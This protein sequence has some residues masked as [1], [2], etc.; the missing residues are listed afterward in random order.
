[1]V[2]SLYSGVAGMV[3]H[4]SKMDVIG[5][6]I[7]NVSTYGYKSSRATFRDVY[8][9]TSS[10]ASAATATSGGTNPTQIGYGAKLGSVDVNH[11]QSTKP[12]QFCLDIILCR[13]RGAFDYLMY[14]YY[15]A[16]MG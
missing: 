15:P 5:N 3:T 9:Q 7:S 1:M 8:Y 12:N 6:N 2:R 14:P 4:Q 11:S 16:Y 13:I 10:S